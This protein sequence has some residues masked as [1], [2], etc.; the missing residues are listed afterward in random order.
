M[1]C[2]VPAVLA[3]GSLCAHSAEWLEMS[4]PS[5]ARVALDQSGIQRDGNVARAW[6]SATWTV[7]QTVGSGDVAY[8]SVQ[9]LMSYHCVRRTSVPLARIFFGADGVELM[10]LNLE[11]VEL[12]QPV[13]PDSVRAQMLELVCKAKPPE[14]PVLSPTA[15]L[16]RYQAGGRRAAA[17]LAG[18]GQGEGQVSAEVGRCRGRIQG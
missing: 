10:R 6:D 11:G 8:R 15:G 1:R 17:S 9:T 14:L 3:L 16:S 5:A 4:S 2:L 18:D 7:D 12:P 13:V